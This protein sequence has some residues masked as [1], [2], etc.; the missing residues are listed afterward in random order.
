MHY[1][2][3]NRY[4]EP[5]VSLLLLGNTAPSE[6]IE[7]AIDTGFSGELTLPQ[8]VIARLN[9][10][11]DDDGVPYI[12]ADGTPR[13]MPRY[14]GQIQWHGQIREVNVIDAGSEALLG[15]QLL[16]GSNL[17]VDASPGGAVT[18]AELR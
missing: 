10:L 16:A 9:L 14:I 18:I 7:F 15:M 12:L 13:V 4:L 1:G 2:T 6:A 3:V 11:R 5:I 8:D 17:N